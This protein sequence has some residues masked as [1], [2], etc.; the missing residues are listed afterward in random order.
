[1]K[2]KSVFS[3]LLVVLFVAISAATAM[4]YDDG[5]KALAAAEDYLTLVLENMNLYT[6][7]D[8]TLGTVAKLQERISIEI[9]TTLLGEVPHYWNNVNSSRLLVKD[10]IDYIV[11]KADY[12]RFFRSFN[13]SYHDEF[14]MKFDCNDIQLSDKY[15]KAELSAYYP[16]SILK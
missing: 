9:D 8:L 15:S 12:Y 3:T 4:A 11:D 13:K 5:E 10:S 7:H 16:G 6:D 2:I 1:M 14:S